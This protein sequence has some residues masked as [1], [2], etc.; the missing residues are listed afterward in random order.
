MKFYITFTSI[1]ELGKEEYSSTAPD[2]K[3]AVRNILLRE[4]PHTKALAMYLPMFDHVGKHG[5]VTGT[6]P[7]IVTQVDNEPTLTEQELLDNIDT[8]RQGL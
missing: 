5:P 6:E 2:I 3:T 1:K 7:F 4:M 8:I